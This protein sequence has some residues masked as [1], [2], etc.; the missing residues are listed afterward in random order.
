MLCRVLME[1]LHCN[2]REGILYYNVRIDMIL[3]SAEIQVKRKP[4]EELLA[5]GDA[6][7]AT[8]HKVEDFRKQ[9]GT[10][11]HHKEGPRALISSLFVDEGYGFLL[12]PEGRK[13]YL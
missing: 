6:F 4:S 5:I 13:K 3:P 11:K 1:V 12:T 10:V 2:H 8:R 7:D 9:R